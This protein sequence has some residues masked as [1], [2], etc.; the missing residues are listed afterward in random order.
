MRV[1]F[2]PLVNPWG[3]L[4]GKRS[5]P[6]GV[7]LMRNAPVHPDGRGTFLVGGQR[8]SPR[9]PWFRGDSRTM[10]VESR[11][12][13]DFMEREVLTGSPAIAVDVHS[14]FGL[15]DRVWFPYART[16]RPFPSLPEVLALKCLLDQTLPH[17][18][19]RVEPQSQAYTVDGDLWDHLY[20]RHQARGSGG[21]FVPLTLEMGSWLWVKKN[22]L[23]LFDP[24]GGFHPMKPHRLRRTLRRHFPLFDFLRRATAGARAWAELDRERRSQLLGDAFDLWYAR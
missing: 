15:V 10:E 3:V 8:W 5:N 20:D 7:D 19:Y 12:L 21:V 11:A 16:R 22:P 24:L 18:V 4:M 17:H 6:R 14:G 13:C 23:Q 1:V 2:V 9:L